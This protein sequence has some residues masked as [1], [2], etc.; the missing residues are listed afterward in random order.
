MR[1]LPQGVGGSNKRVRRA[2]TTNLTAEEIHQIGL[3]EV[4]RIEGEMLEIARKLGFNDLK[5]FNKAVDGNPDLKAKSRDQILDIYRGYEAQMYAQLPK[6]SGRLPK[7]KLNVVQM[8]AFR[9]KTSAGADYNTGAADGSRPGRIN[10][11]TSEP[12]SRKTITTE[13]TAYHEG[14]PGHHMQLSIAQEMTDLPQFRRNGGYTAYVEGWA[15]YSE[16]LG[17]EVGF[18]QNPYN[19]YGRLN[20][21]MLRALPLVADTGLNTTKSTRAH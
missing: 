12:T 16:R 13:S 15:L 9:E 14:V 4:A 7:A 10:V 11:N 8:E 19:D 1:Y 21:E 17:K 5:S 18:Y 20:D 3:R 6:L 2:T